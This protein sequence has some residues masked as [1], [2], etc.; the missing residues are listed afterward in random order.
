M[1]C[2]PRQRLRQRDL[3]LS[4]GADHLGGAC[5]GI[6][7]A[8]EPDH[9]G[10]QVEEFLGYCSGDRRDG[11][12]AGRECKHGHSGVLRLR[13]FRPERSAAAGGAGSDRHGNGE[14]QRPVEKGLHRVRD[15]ADAGVRQGRS[16]CPAR[17]GEKAAERFPL[18]Q[19]PRVEFPVFGEECSG[20]CVQSSACRGCE[21]GGCAECAGSGAGASGG[22]NCEGGSPQGRGNPCGA[23][24]SDPGLYSE[25][26]G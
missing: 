3:R 19:L 17:S 7:H 22:S 24:G 13:L 5:A 18:R 25:P 21:A 16:E 15:A 23:D 4:P 2:R 20:R 11:S 8:R 10:Q 26:A 9:Q 14:E 6:C 1:R 12:A